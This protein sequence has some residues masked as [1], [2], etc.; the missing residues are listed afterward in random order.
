MASQDDST[1]STSSCLE[2][3]QPGEPSALVRGAA[4]S[5][6]AVAPQLPT[7]DELDRLSEDV[8]NA[9]A[10]GGHFDPEEDTRIL[11]TFGRY[12]RVRGAL[13]QIVADLEPVIWNFDHVSRRDRMGAF[14]VA[15]VAACLLIRSSTRVVERFAGLPLVHEK[16]DQGEPRFGIPRKQFTEIYRSRTNPLNYLRFE[17]GRTFARANWE[18]II[19]LEELSEVVDL[20]GEEHQKAALFSKSRSLLDGFRYRVHSD[21]RRRKSS[22]KKVVFSMFELGGRS[23]S[24]IHNPLHVKAVTPDVVASVR[25]ILRPGDAIVTRHADAVTNLFL[26]GFWPHS[27]LYI[28]TQAEREKLGVRMDLGRQTRS[29]DP[30]CV[31]EALKDGVHFRK[32]ENTLKVDCF[33]IIRPKLDPE[34]LAEGL[35]RAVEHEGKGYDFEFDFSRSDRIV[36]T[37][38][39]YRGFHGVGGLDFNLTERAGRMTLAAEDLLDR[40]VDDQGYEVVAVFGVGGIPVTTGAEAKQR[41]I[42]S[43]R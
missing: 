17:I 39:I 24:S 9:N 10:R 43:Y 23:V 8:A 28:G 42:A 1:Y 18:E 16:L 32:L 37:E 30:S 13:H 14:A 34:S 6:L 21:A 36:C 5:L 40:A 19:G 41:L 29:V 38:V 26:P 27:A 22:F 25:N 4:A 3:L 20:M 2:D 7:A 12:L 33:T 11:N 15:Y 35:S 31:L